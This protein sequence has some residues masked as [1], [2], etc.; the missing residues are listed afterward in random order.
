MKKRIF[1]FAL[2]LIMI[3]GAAFSLN[4][5]A[6]SKELRFDENGEFKIM[7]LADCQDEFPATEKMLKFIDASIKAY[8]PDIVVLGGDNVVAKNNMAN[9]IKEIVDIFVANK[10]YFTVTFGNHDHQQDLTD[11]EQ[12]AV[13]QQAGGEYC[14]A[15]DPH[16]E[17]TGTATHALPILGSKSDETKYMLYMFDSNDYVRDENGKELGLGY[18]CV[19][20]DQIEWY[21]ETS[22]AAE[23]AAGKKVPAMAFQHIIVGE[24][25][26]ALFRETSISLGDVI[27]PSYNGKTYSFFPKLENIEDGFIF[28]YPCPGYYNYGQF[29]AMVERG[30]VVAIFSG[31]D[32]PNT[33]TTEV[34]GIKIINTGGATYH[35]YGSEF[36]RGM[37][38]I[39]LNENDLSTFE[40]EQVTVNQFAIDNPEFAE[41]VGINTFVAKLTVGFGDFLLAITKFCG[42]FSSVITFIFG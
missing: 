20:K 38:M 1:S 28:E 25:Y 29:D 39:T 17:L 40:T 13:Y 4:A 33:F 41:A 19:N 30:D 8:Q 7:H 27:T 26:D 3:F 14:L 32:H 2:A 5:S 18:D 42:I 16:P 31:H 36:S 23:T 9:G 21:K 12:L 35:S 6:A 10:T 15:T 11:D 24:V 34:D 37:R 22:K